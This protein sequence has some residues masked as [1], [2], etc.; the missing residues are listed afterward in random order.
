MSREVKIFDTTLRDGEQSPGA[1]M[2]EDQKIEVAFTLERLGIDRIEAGFPVSSPVQFNA[3]K[4]IA[5]MLDFAT[6]V[7]LA[8]CVEITKCCILLL[9]LPRFIETL[10]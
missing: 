5:D 4:R 3:V 1:A 6:V 10:N 2:S 7:G 9:P 8:R